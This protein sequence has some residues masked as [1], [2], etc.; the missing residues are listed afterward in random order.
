MWKRIEGSN[1]SPSAMLIDPTLLLP[2]A[3][4]E[5]TLAFNAQIQQMTSGLPPM[6]SFTPDEIR[7]ARREGVS[8]WGPIIH[9]EFATTREIEGPAGPIELRVF[10]TGV[11]N[12]VFLH[13]HGGGWVLG[14]ND[15]MDPMLEE[16]SRASATTVI[17][18]EY[19][20]AP[21]NPYPAGLEDCVAAAR[22]LIN[23][24]G[25]AF[26]TDRIVIGG[27]S[28][29]A[30][31]AAASMLK[32]RDEDGFDDWAGAN[33]VYG[34]YMPSGTPSVRLWD[35]E[36]LVLDQE[37]MEWFG[38]HYRGGAEIDPFDPYYA[39]LF[40]DVADLG[41]AL[42]TVGTADPL[43]DDSL[44]MASRWAAAANQTDLHIAPG[45][46]HGF[47]AFPTILAKEARHRMHAFIRD[48]ID[49]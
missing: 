2:E 13:L 27:E 7:R 28:S 37:V 44:F 21:E 33:L 9:S 8:I 41:A 49:R 11:T 40:G 24:S 14:N 29:G 43:L 6:T 31:L 48:A 16:L 38:N 35:K 1:P 36:G 5:E 42:F 39:P 15:M 32:I 22:W 17:S 34:S 30:N 3:V 45:G 18:V 47:D 19:R 4:S 10:D 25:S 23:N 46:I 12:G 20:L 26:G